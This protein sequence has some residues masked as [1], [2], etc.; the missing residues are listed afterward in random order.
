MPVVLGMKYDTTIDLTVIKRILKEYYKKFYTDKFGN[1]L[2]M[3]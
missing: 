2:D 1:V 3:D